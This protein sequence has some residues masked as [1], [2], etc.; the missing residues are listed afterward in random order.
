MVT[1]PRVW[2]VTPEIHRSGGTERSVAEQVE[3][4]REHFTIRLYTMLAEDVDLDHVSVRLIPRPPG[5]HLLRYLWWFIANHALRWWDRGRLDAPDVT[6]SPGINCLDADAISVHIVFGRYWERVREGGL[7]TLSRPREVL[8]GL[9][10]ILYWNLLQLLERWVYTGRATLWALSQE[11]AADI[12][13]RFHRPASTVPAIPNG[14]DIGHFSPERRLALRSDSRARLSVA[15]RRVLLLVGNDAYKKG[16]DR[17]LAALTRLPEDVVL[18][19]A[20]DVDRAALQVRAKKLGVDRRMLVWPPTASILDYYSAADILIAPSRDEASPLPPL[21]AAACGLPIVISSSTGAAA[22]LMVDGQH[23]LVLRDAEDPVELAQLIER[24]LNDRDLATG[25]GQAARALAEQCSWDDNARTARALLEREATTPR[26]L[27]LLPQVD[28]VGGIE[29]AS[30]SLLRAVGESYGPERVGLVSSRKA[31]GDLSCR[32]L[33]AGSTRGERRGTVAAKVS[34]L[35]HALWAAWRWRRRLFVLACHPHHAPIAWA[36]R[37]ITRCPYA[38]WCHGLE[39][40]GGLPRWVG[41]ALRRAQLVFAP[42]AFTARQAEEAA[43]LAPGTVKLLHHCVPPEL[44]INPRSGSNGRRRTVLTVARLSPEDSYK[45]VDTLLYAWPQ[46]TAR[47]PE[48]ELVIV[49]DGADRSRLEKIAELIGI[50]GSICFMGRVSDHELAAAYGEAMLFALPA[51]ARLSPSPQGE[52]FGLV[53]LE[54]AAAGLPVI[55]G[56]AGGAPEA[57]EE[58]K[59]GF[60]VDPD[61]PTDVAEAI[62]CLLSEPA[63]AMRMGEAGRRWAAEH[64]SYPRFR[65]DIARL[66]NKTSSISR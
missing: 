13:A 48:A 47:I 6:Y 63:L 15:N 57:L 49:G 55:A 11:D 25:L 34:L 5:P 16:V 43:G 36:C 29:R 22:E 20:G 38:V 40:W 26:I 66:V 65:S 19:V 7:R 32:L 50:G 45:G 61:E 33:H 1:K 12:E 31:K 56:R 35:V 10:R 30:R 54:A 42:S 39:S 27:L 62:C 2:I 52:G 3:R 64:F 59:T 18:A 23:A 41:F 53:F 51:R 44:P 14:V 58:G 60:L 4:W 24:I 17:G 9:H 8:V 46:V 28:G 21:E 37:V